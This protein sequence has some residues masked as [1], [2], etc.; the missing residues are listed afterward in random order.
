MNI[1]SEIEKVSFNQGK[2]TAMILWET[3]GDQQKVSYQEMIQKVES[4]SLILNEIGLREGN[5]VA[6]VAESKPE[7]VFA[8][9]AILKNKGTAVL[10]DAS[11]PAEELKVLIKK[12]R[13]SAIYASATQLEKIIEVEKMPILNVSEGGIRT[14][15]EVCDQTLLDGDERIASIIFSSG[16]TKVASG[17]MHGHDGI[18]GSALMCV[19]NNGV[20]GSD[21]FFGILPNSHIYGLYTQVIAPL[22]LGGS[23]CFIESLDAACLLGA[24]QGYQPTVFPAVPKVFELLKTSIMKKIESKKSTKKIFDRLFPICLK[25]RKA[26]GR[27]LGKIVFGSIHKGFG[28]KMKIMASAGAPM[29]VKTAEF[30]YGVGFNML[31]TYG[32]TE[33]SIPTIGNYG[34]HITV[35]SCGRPYPEVMVK[36]DESGE[37]LIQSPYMMLGYFDDEQAT[38]EAF[39]EDGWFKTGDL[40]SIDEHG[41]IRIHGRCKDNIVLA[42]GKKIAPDDIENAYDGILGVKELVICGIADEQAGHDNVHAFVVADGVEEATIRQRLKERGKTLSQNMRLREIHFVNEIPKTSLQKPKRYLLKKAISH[43]VKKEVV[44]AKK[45][46][47]TLEAFVTKVI[48]NLAQVPEEELKGET[49]FLQELSI[50]SLSSIQLALDIEEFSGVDVTERLKIDMTI[51][52]LV[53]VIKEGNVESEHKLDV[54]QYPQDKKKLHYGVFAFHRWLVG[55]IYK[56]KIQNDSVIPK[57]QGYL[58]CSNHVTNFDY[59]ILT[60]NFRRKEFQQFGCMAKQELFKDKR[61]NR[62][63]INTAGM[64]PV[65]RSGNASEAIE[66]VKSKLKE[67]WG[68]L[69]HPEGTRS[70]D[71]NM[72]EYKKGI[73]AIAIESG[74][75]IIP[76]YIK[77]GHEI[78]PPSQ[79]MPNLF[80]FKK[81][82]RYSLEVIYGEPIDAENWTAEELIEKVV[83]ETKKLA[84]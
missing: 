59:L 9:L 17:I 13:L 7:W 36:L 71:G 70:K 65:N 49:C 26:T 25:K 58:L 79:N 66:V 34:D 72:G 81:W 27:N 69:I 82:R 57:N 3:K 63:L 40:G 46:K 6:I 18:I 37:I 77:G 12:S 62:L 1:Y 83:F 56:V 21:R 44:E 73:A 19:N 38:K 67:N 5:R 20:D 51:A 76:A 78:F 24:L 30:Y 74:V 29:D 35:D 11:L 75:P 48:A 52:Q 41:D 42:T 64:I 68:I 47:L 43:K 31:I 50:D 33:T 15:N 28:G 45:E 22:I 39:T 60:Q 54:S 80:N 61:V 10:L 14:N 4:Y 32:A 2:K 53:E 84:K 23:V 8:Y 55:T 16:T